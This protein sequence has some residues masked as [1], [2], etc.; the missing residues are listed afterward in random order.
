LL[1]KII[2]PN[3]RSTRAANRNNVSKMTDIQYWDDIFT[4]EI[5]AINA[6][7]EKIPSMDNPV[8]KAEAIE[9]C[10]ARIRSAAGTKRSFK[11]EIRLV[12]DVGQRRNYEARLQQLDQQLQTAQADLK[13]LEG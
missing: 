3:E 5:D 12:Q 2:T 13:A 11:M 1:V 8:E 9:R 6:M 10:N 4:E 7:V